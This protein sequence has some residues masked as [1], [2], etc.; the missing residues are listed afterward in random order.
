VT[1]PKG[2]PALGGTGATVAT[3]WT[4]VPTAAGEGVP[5]TAVVVLPEP[6]ERFAP[7]HASV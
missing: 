3:R 4:A 5:V 6:I 2:V 7:T 1:D